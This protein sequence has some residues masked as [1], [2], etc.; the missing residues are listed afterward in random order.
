MP[1]QPSSARHHQIGG[2]HYVSKAVQPW[3]A[4][5]AWMSSEAF[6]GFLQGNVIKYMAR[7]RDKGGVQ[8]LRKAAHYLQRLIEEEEMQRLIEDEERLCRA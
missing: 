1:K 6:C 3:D 5:Q 8:D 7:Y 4:M 2:E